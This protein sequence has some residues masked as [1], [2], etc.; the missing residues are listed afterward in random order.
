M[1]FVVA[2][3]LCFAELG[4]VIPRSGGE[5]IY[6]LETFSRHSV[7]WGELPAFLCSWTY[8][9]VLKPAVCAVIIMTCAEYAIEPF[10]ATIGLHELDES[11]KRTVIK[12]LAVMF[13]AIITYINLMST[14]LYVH[15]NNVF[16][17][18]KLAACLLIIGVGIW[19]LAIGNTANLSSGFV[20]TTSD[21]G[22][23]ALAFYNGLWAYDGWAS[24]T[25]L[26]E[27]IK[28]PEK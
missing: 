24:V 13:L 1:S 27:E 18:G 3:A 12:L 28:N 19:Q 16:T 23:I 10:S 7:F 11:D 22:R 4:T 8:L 26:T 14:K 21:P 2:G 25:I 9:L 15:I 20:G 5:Y 17:Y 6:I